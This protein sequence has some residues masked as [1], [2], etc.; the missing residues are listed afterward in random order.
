M[1]HH[2]VATLLLQRRGLEEF[3][4]TVYVGEK[5]GSLVLLTPPRHQSTTL[6]AICLKKAKNTNVPNHVVELL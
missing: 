5:S 2:K 6:E 1:N 4:F 3:L